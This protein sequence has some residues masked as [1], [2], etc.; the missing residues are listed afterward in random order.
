MPSRRSS[1]TVAEHLPLSVREEQTRSLNPPCT[2]TDVTDP[3]RLAPGVYFAQIDQDWAPGLPSASRLRSADGICKDSFLVGLYISAQGCRTYIV[4]VGWHDLRRLSPDWLR[5]HRAAMRRNPDGLER[6]QQSF[7]V[8]F[9]ITQS[10]LPRT[11]TRRSPTPNR[12]TL[13]WAASGLCHVYQS[14]RLCT[15]PFRRSQVRKAEEV[16]PIDPA[17]GFMKAAFCASTLRSTNGATS[18][19]MAPSCETRLHERSRY[20]MT[21][22]NLRRSTRRP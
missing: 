20:D 14:I 12:T 21:R 1:R 4:D 3:E 5:Q 18:Q 2:C 11:R 16:S 9:T 10:R 19:Q 13:Q 8:W 7:N 6:T 22:S 17:S 15:L